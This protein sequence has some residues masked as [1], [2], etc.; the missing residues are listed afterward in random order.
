MH[1]LS[2]TADTRKVR[3][4]H[5][6]WAYLLPLALSVSL[7]AQQAAQSS[8][9]EEW[10][11]QWTQA[12]EAAAPARQRALEQITRTIAAGP[13]RDDWQ[14]LEHHG[15][16]VWFQDAK[17]GIFLHWG[18]FSVPAFG[19]EWY[20]RNMYQQGTPEFAHQVATY[21]PQSKFGYKDFIPMFRMEHFDPNAWAELFRRAGARYV[22]P[23]AEHHDGFAMYKTEL[24][25]WNAVE[26]G[27]HRDLIGD[28][29][30]AAQ[31][32][33]LKF[34]VSFH[35]AEHDW[36]FDGGRHFD[37]DVNDAK[38]AGFYGPAELRDNYASDET[39]AKEYTFVSEEF[40]TDW[41]ARTVEL[42]SRYHPDLVY[43]DWWV[44]YPEFR[45]YQE[46]SAAFYFD[47]AAQRNQ[48]VVMFSK[49]DNMA[50]G[51]GTHDVER[52]ALP[53]IEKLPW[54]TDTSISNASWGYLEHDTFKTPQMILDQLIDVVSK[55]GNLLLNI[56]PKPDGTIPDEAAKAL[57]AIGG[58]LDI[59]GEA[60]YG[61]RPWR[62][63]G[64]GPTRVKSGS[65]QDLSAP[66]YT[67][68]DFRFTTHNGLL[69]AIEMRPPAGDEAVVHSL[70]T[71]LPGDGVVEEVSMLG[72]SGKLTWHQDAEGLHIHVP[73]ERVGNYPSTFRVKLQ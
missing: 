15:T 18:L 14:S 40:R 57:L 1:Y 27:P 68:Q 62:S 3:L 26:M 67:A 48:Q 8:T 58:W 25:P 2:L 56:G 37:S 73:G 53:E 36:F 12:S 4:L 52:G 60:I 45:A 32:H 65:F 29:Q 30:S 34:G 33:G 23:V 51:A 61:S 66:K 16:P 19:N 31:S 11:R 7:P 17:F 72:F 70:A 22:V 20:S 47:Q 43:F 42:E 10:N 5:M 9:P 49:Y 6:N 38:Y 24:S 54:Q 41:L 35:R 44:G 46:R 50:P 13:Y 59:N 28:L 39:L 71:G 63:F 64:E 55:N 21:G 69:Y